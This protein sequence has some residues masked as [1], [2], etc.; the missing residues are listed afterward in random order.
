MMAT[1]MPNLLVAGIAQ[2]TYFNFTFL[3]AGTASLQSVTHVL[4]FVEGIFIPGP[5]IPAGWS[6]IYAMDSLH[7]STLALG[8][9][10]VCLL[11]FAFAVAW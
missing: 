1:F 6:W 7:W 9:T 11:T 5:S 8:T 3:F 10:Q 4:V 2:G